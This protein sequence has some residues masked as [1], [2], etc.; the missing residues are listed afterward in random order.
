MRAS[1]G[2]AL[3]GVGLLLLG[4]LLFLPEGSSGEHAGGAAGRTDRADDGGAAS[5]TAGATSATQVDAEGVSRSENPPTRG[6]RSVQ[7]NVVDEAGEPVAGMQ[8]RA[9][10]ATRADLPT[11]GD[12]L[13]MGSPLTRQHEASEAVLS[14]ERGRAT[15]TTPGIPCVFVAR[16]PQAAG[17]A[18]IGEIPRGQLHLRVRRFDAQTVRVLGP[19]GLP[20]AGIGVCAREDT[21]RQ[22]DFHY[23][24]VSTDADG[25]A[26]LP[27]FGQTARAAWR[28]GSVV[29][30]QAELLGDVVGVDYAEDAEIPEVVELQI[31]RCG[32]VEVRGFAEG[33]PARITLRSGREGKGHVKWLQ[34]TTIEGSATFPA[35]QPGS[36]TL[37]A[38]L[39]VDGVAGT[40]VVQGP[41]PSYNENRVVLDFSKAKLLRV[42]GRIR[43]AE[44]APGGP[45]V[46]AMGQLFLAFHARGGGSAELR[47]YPAEDGSFQCLVDRSGLEMPMEAVVARDGYRYG[48]KR[49][50]IPWTASEFDVGD[51]L[52]ESPPVLAAGR[53]ESVAGEP[54]GGAE[55]RATAIPDGED[56]VYRYPHDLAHSDADGSFRIYR[57][58]P[59]CHGDH[60]LAASADGHVPT[61]VDFR[62]GQPNL[63]VR[64]TPAA[65]VRAWWRTQ[66]TVAVYLEQLVGEEVRRYG[67]N[68][69][70]RHEDGSDHAEW[71]ELAAGVYDLVVR[72]PNDLE[73]LRIHGIDVIAGELTVDPRV[74]G[75][76][77]DHRLRRAT[78]RVLAEGGSA[79]RDAEFLMLEATRTRRIPDEQVAEST[80]SLLLLNEGQVDL[81]VTAPRY[82]PAK[83][84]HLKNHA[85]VSL[86]LGTPISI[87]F[88]VQEDQ[89][90]A[91]LGSEVVLLD[92]AGQEVLG[93]ASCTFD[94]QYGGGRELWKAA[95]FPPGAG[96]YQLMWV[97]PQ[98]RPA[99][100]QAQAAPR[101]PV[102]IR[103][104]TL[105][106]RVMVTAPSAFWSRLRR[107]D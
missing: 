74:Q 99:T 4:V 72:L 8:V 86:R 6:A 59:Q 15:V 28:R 31:G 79:P 66:E 76:E 7:V 77:I 17:L 69:T 42:S 2:L 35:V 20:M 44:A 106:G 43:E 94:R 55:L 22:G 71:T 45:P 18:A 32:R 10:A 96:A 87:C 50:W 90:E 24:G 57:F 61:S 91:L 62:P 39:R 101:S 102:H 93:Q 16:S 29:A 34:R 97:A 75:L 78:V 47:L 46:S 89:R 1:A 88:L 5:A 41:A 11:L 60:L 92:A 33:L 52:M 63:L 9:Y 73:V 64:L 12:E 98:R 53:V 30:L 95:F 67:P 58:A 23:P 51:L 68:E 48:E 14:D 70:T 49:I 54:I 105:G 40:A 85:E 56:A 37:T 80:W 25:I 3:A 36:H 81:L 38:E 107:G 83:V 19:G 65:G 104:E 21:V 103:E 84:V 100:A 26:V 27:W 82:A 13:M